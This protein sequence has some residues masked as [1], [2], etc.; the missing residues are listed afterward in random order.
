MT[1]VWT[2]KLQGLCGGG[3]QSV[4]HKEFKHNSYGALHVIHCLIHSVFSKAN[5]VIGCTA[6]SDEK[7]AFQDVAFV[8]EPVSC[9]MAN[10]CKQSTWRC[11]TLLVVFACFCYVHSLSSVGVT[12]TESYSILVVSTSICLWRLFVHRLMLR[13]RQW[14]KPRTC[15]HQGSIQ[16][17]KAQR[18]LWFIDVSCNLQFLERNERVTVRHRFKCSQSAAWALWKSL[19]K[20]S[21]TLAVGIMVCIRL[22]YTNSIK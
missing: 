11:S 16:C 22:S 20:K 7:I 4:G 3:D 18:Q 8:G 10:R 5:I 21:E 14:G 15:E 6:F 13:S 19:K 9:N 12:S 1:R 2:V 17:G